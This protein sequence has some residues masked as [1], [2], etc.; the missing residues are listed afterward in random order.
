M[1]SS[2]ETFTIQAGLRPFVH[3]YLKP[4]DNDFPLIDSALLTADGSMCLIQ[5]TTGQ[6]HVFDV[7]HL[8]P[9][10]NRFRHLSLTLVSL[11]FLIISDKPENVLRVL[12][13]CESSRQ[14]A[15]DLAGPPCGDTRVSTAIWTEYYQQVMDLQ[16]HGLHFDVPNKRMSPI[17]RPVEFGR[18]HE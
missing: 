2:L 12:E 7:A 3:I 10:I 11:H 17:T 13:F 6:S 15:L 1:G 18:A 8:V 14:A 4:A 9:L 5:V 16:F